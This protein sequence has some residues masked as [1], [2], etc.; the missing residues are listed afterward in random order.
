VNP[1]A[2]GFSPFSLTF[3]RQDREQDLSGLTVT[4]PP[5]LIGK[6]AGI[7]QCPEA[8]AAAGSCP[9]ASKVGTATAAAGSGSDPLWQSGTVYL[10][11][12]Y[13]GA[14]FGLS[15]VVP[16]VAGPYN[17]GNVIARAAIYI[18]PNTAQVTVV[19]DPLPQ[20]VDGVPLRVKTV[21][22]TVGGE[23]NFTFNPTN[24]APMSVSATITS[25]Q[26]ASDNVSTPFEATN[27]AE[28]PFKPSLTATTQGKASKLSGAGLTIKV[29]PPPGNANI[30]KVDLEIPKQLPSRLTTLQ[31]ACTEAQFNANPAGCPEASNIGTAKAYTPVLASPLVGPAYLVSHGNA[32][33][34]DVEFVLQAEGVRIDLDGKTQIKKGI[35][36]SHFETVPD[37]PVT[38]FEATLPEGPHSIFA[39][40]LPQSAKYNL[41][42]QALSM[43]TTITGQNGAVVKQT[44]K[45]AI[46]GCAK[47]KAVKKATK[48]K[49]KKA[50]KSTRS[51][52]K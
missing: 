52:K 37:A 14:P 50:T 20:S 48:K 26:G 7:P 32:A 51:S 28:L 41:C 44:T 22:V 33:F 31:K 38:R 5:G 23:N 21:N 2:G 18:D 27:C 47:K 6:I 39:T 13:K 25:V 15:V 11:G 16:A 19:S 24:C 45:I 29:V 30:A 3:S 8:Q 35:T 36:Y 1:Q 42:G 46:S 49:K 9:A 43:P 40:N 10:T 34:P 17:L 12:P 4:M